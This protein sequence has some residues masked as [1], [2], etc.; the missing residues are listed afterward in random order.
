MT[1]LAPVL[2]RYWD[3]PQSWTLDTYRRHDGYEGLRIALGMEPDQV[4]QTVKDAGLR[5]RGGAGFPTGMKWG[6]IPQG[7]GPDGTVKP[8][9]L[10]VNAD[11]SEPGT[12][13]DIPLLMATP[14]ALVEGAIIASYAIR[15]NTAFIYL[16]GEVVPVLRRLRAAVDQAYAAGLL[17][18][19]ILGSGFDLEL[20]VHAGAGAYICGEETALLDSLEG[21]RGQPRLRPPFPAVA[22]LY[23]CPTVVNNVES[24][25]SVPPILR[26]GT[27]WFRSM[28]SEKSPGFTIY[29]LSGHVTRPGQYEA[30]LGITLRELLD[31]AGGVRAGHRLKFWT[32]GGSSTPLFT[33]EH[34]DVPLDYEGVAAAGSML[35]T[36]ALQ[37][38]DETTCVV[39]A[40]L[41]WTEFYA[42]ES[43][44]KCT[45]CREGTYWLVQ[46]LRR[47]ETGGGT[48][49]DLDTLLDITDSINGKSFCALG[50]GAASPIVSSVK[51][52]RDEYLAHMRGDG[53]PFD[54]ARSTA[55]A[56]AG[57]GVR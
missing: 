57:E 55:W 27:D 20:I 38:F 39:R 6:F 42:H 40:V 2:T 7:P 49:A 1:A 5:G 11:E 44:G 35:G 14:H 15:A 48:E 10:V 22:G 19:D 37:I 9:Y 13:K 18:H 25:A 4:I 43:C 26:Y 12:C 33:D 16:R 8:H 29:S 51:Y 56:E 34:L 3:D 17:G 54:P 45:P 46:L 28:G 36:K 32:P 30:P 47:I 52:F 50:D 21:R 23:A 41:R 24:I 31:Y 53:C